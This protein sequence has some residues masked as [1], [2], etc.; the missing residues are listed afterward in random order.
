MQSKTIILSNNTKHGS[1]TPRAI[2]TFIS[3]KNF[4]DGKLRLYNLNQL[5][6]DVKLGIYY[7]QKVY[8]SALSKHLGYYSFSFDENFDLNHPIYCAL[9]N[10]SNKVVVM[11]GGIQNGFCFTDD[12]E[13]LAQNYD[14]ENQIDNEIIDAN[15]KSNNL[16]QDLNEKKEEL[17]QKN[18]L[19]EFDEY[20]DFDD[21]KVEL[22]NQN[23]QTCTQC[24]CNHCVYKEYFFNNK[25]DNPITKEELVPLNSEFPHNQSTKSIDENAD[26]QVMLSSETQTETP[27]DTIGEKFMSS[28]SEQL[29]VMF[30]T[31][32]LDETIMKIL[33]NSRIIKVTDSIDNRPYILG[34]LYENN[35]IKYLIYGVPS[36]YNATPPIELGENYQWL[37]LSPDDPMSDGYYVLY[38]DAT[39]G[40]LVPVKVE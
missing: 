18:L 11:S 24:E 29:D 13:N 37:P 40:K 25:E 36:S 8:T 20:K 39:D 17:P 10:T 23:A 21:K 27:S 16:I 7:Q 33:P 1:N 4:I 5:D 32:P 9:I 31:Y 15:I 30:Q 19:K 28:I 26:N 38:Q 35:S 6:N 34:V 2:L 14:Q 3:E 12:L 22:N